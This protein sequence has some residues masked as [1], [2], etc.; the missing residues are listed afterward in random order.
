ML[1]EAAHE[2]G[3]PAGVF[4]VVC[5]S[6]RVVGEAIVGHPDVDMV[7]FTGSLQA[8]RRVASLAGEG[9]KRV[10][11]RARRQVA[12]RGAGRCAVRQGD[13][14]RREQLHAELRADVLRLD[15]D[16]R[17]ARAAGRGHRS[18]QGAAR[19]ADGWRSVRSEDAA[20]PARVGQPARQRARLHRA[21]QDGGRGA[22]CRRRPSGALAKGFYVEPTVFANVRNRWTS[23]RRR[24]SG[25][26]WRSFRTTARTRRFAWPTIRSTGSRAACG[27]A[28]RSARCRWRGGCAPGQVDING[29][30]FNPMAPFGG[31]KKSGIGR[32]LG[33]KALDEFYQ[34]KA[35]QR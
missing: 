31:Y 20:R 29:G 3:L 26:C 2:I 24:S 33:P 19:Q 4:N 30:R 10:T 13:P 18:R 16:A 15:A 8:G 34:L 28:R 21:R 35:I 6:G 12:V 5:G 11:S 1:A 25:R 32:E 9:I 14:G 7:S 22:R 17:A 27:R 23:R